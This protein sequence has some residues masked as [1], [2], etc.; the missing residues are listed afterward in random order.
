MSKCLGCGIKLQY[1]DEKALGF[2]PKKDSK[3]CQR[4]FK[5]QNYH[6]NTIEE[7]IMKDQ[8]ILTKINE[9]KSFTFFLTDIL[10][11]NK[12]VINLYEKINSPKVL[13]ITKIDILPKN[14]KY[15]ILLNNIKRIYHISDIILFS[16][17]NGYGQNDILKLCQK[18]K[19]V[20][21]SG[22]TSSGKSSLI[23]YLFNKKLTTSEYQNTTQDF[24]KIKLALF[25]FLCE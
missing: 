1:E 13:V 11:L 20:I 4:C 25:K 7:N 8:D 3:Y 2:T 17:V 5:L 18:E 21:F 22:P 15:E 23:N 19:E 24:I 14:L 16:Q 12:K 10:N 9:K 6:E